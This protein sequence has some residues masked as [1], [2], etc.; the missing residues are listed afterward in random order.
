MLNAVRN[1]LSHLATRR[2]ETWRPL[3]AVYYL[4]YACEFRCPFCSD[5]SGT[6]YHRLPSPILDGPEVLALLARIRRASDHLVL[7]GGEPLSHPDVDHVLEHL[8]ALRFDGVVFTTRG[9]GL[10]P[11]LPAVARSI[12]KLVISI[13]TLDERKADRWLGRGTGSLRRVL[14][15][16]DAAA[17]YPGRSYEIVVS[18]VATPDNLTDLLG[19]YD[20]ARSR[21][22]GFALCPQLR[23][24]KAHEELHGNADYRRLYDLLIAEKRRGAPIF[25][26]VQYLEY[27]RDLRKFDC[28]PSAVL[29]VSPTGDV[30]YPCL[31]LGHVAGNLRQEPDLDRIR[32]MGQD[33]FGPEPSCDTRCHSACALSLSLALNHPHTLLHELALRTKAAVAGFG[34]GPRS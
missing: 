9:P 14:E 15:E 25:G 30:F 27:M 19:V 23:G 12:R 34:G 18:S 3:L 11:H 5:G 32:R 4:T 16:A 24:V 26:T 1:Y 10:S 29:A 17:R 28:R 8:P 7:T 6:P 13:D 22:F 21:G 2:P 31:E 33:K 20:Y